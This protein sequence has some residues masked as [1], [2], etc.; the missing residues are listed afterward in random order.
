MSEVNIDVERIVRE[1][2]A[3]LDGTAASSTPVQATEP[4]VLRITE[5]LVT[6]E[7]IEDAHRD[8]LTLREKHRS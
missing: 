3:H 6:L 5:R 4:G 1:V 8:L 7:T 2:M